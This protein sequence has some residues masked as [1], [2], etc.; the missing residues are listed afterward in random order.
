MPDRGEDG[1]LDMPT[2]PD[3]PVHG[4]EG[5]VAKKTAAKKAVAKKAAAEKAGQGPRRTNRRLERAL[6][7]VAALRERVTQLEAEVLECRRLSKR[8]AEVTDVVAEVLLPAEQRDEARLR[9]LLAQY[10][11]TF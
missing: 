9:D 8:L 5:E 6:G 3:R 1:K 7:E 11:R 4:G 10:D 2:N